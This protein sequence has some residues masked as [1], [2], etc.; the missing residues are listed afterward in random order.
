MPIKKNPKGNDWCFGSK[1]GFKTKTDAEAAERAYYASM[2]KESINIC[3]TEIAKAVNEEKRIFKCVVLRP[4]QFDDDGIY[5]DYYSKE[6]VEKAAHQ[7][8]MFCNQG[9]EGHSNSNTELIKFV[10]SG[11][12][13]VDYTLGDGEVKAGDWVAAVKIFDDGIW[14]RCKKG[15][16]T[17]F[18]IGCKALVEEIDE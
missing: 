18:S 16:Y 15:E 3:N 13:D 7:F 12:A 10:E 14:E 11:I 1:C 4:G 6:T 17:G 2:D 8:M 9:N 5:E